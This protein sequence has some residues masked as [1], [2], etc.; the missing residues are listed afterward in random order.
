MTFFF[1]VGARVG[2]FCVGTLVT[3]ALVG[4]VGALVGIVGT[5]VGPVG[6]LVG[7]VG[8]LVGLVGVLEGLLVVGAL[9]GLLVAGALVGLVGSLEGS[10]LGPAEGVWDGAFARALSITTLGVTSPQ[11]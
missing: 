11:V 7:I 6:A 8:V 5:L 10:T 9:E 3:G 1:L 4:I 2:G